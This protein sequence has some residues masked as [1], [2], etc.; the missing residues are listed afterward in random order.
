[1][2]SRYRRWRAKRIFKQIMTALQYC[3]RKSIT[4]RD[5]KLENILV[6]EI[7]GNHY[8]IKISDFGLSAFE[9][10]AKKETDLCGTPGYIAPEIY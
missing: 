10:T 7:E 1:M 6:N 8:H 5:I 2:T 3:H 4:H 9:E